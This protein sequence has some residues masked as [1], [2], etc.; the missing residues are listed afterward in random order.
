[1]GKLYFVRHGE[2]EWNTI[3]R[4]CGATDIPLTDRGRE[5]AKE[6]AA[7]IIEEGIKIDKIIS[8][9]LSRAYETAKIIGEELGLDVKKDDRI[10]EQNFGIWEGRYGKGDKEFQEAKRMFCSSYSGGES[11]MKTAQRVYNLIDEVKK[12]R[13]H[14]Y[15]LVAHNGIYRIIQ[16]YF[17]D[18]T[19]EEFAMQSMSNCEIKVYEI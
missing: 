1:M 11:M 19:N 7:R 16:S 13:D 3:G 18:L 5:M 14:T 15:L 9:P 10:K 4:I 6:T 8:S 17:F 2:S 12:D